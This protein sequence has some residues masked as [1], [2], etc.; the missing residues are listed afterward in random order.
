MRA[1]FPARWRLCGCWSALRSPAGRELAVPLAEL[2]GKGQGLRCGGGLQFRLRSLQEALASPEHWATQKA[3]SECPQSPADPGRRNKAPDL[4]CKTKA[5]CSQGLQMS[6]CFH[7]L[8]SFPLPPF[9]FGFSPPLLSPEIC[10]FFLL[11]TFSWVQAQAE[12]VLASRCE[13]RLLD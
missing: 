8:Q 2:A 3:S 4:F 13:H 12:G 1:E 10:L 6:C 11:F 5:R 9:F 7:Y